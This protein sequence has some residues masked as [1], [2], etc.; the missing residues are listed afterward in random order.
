MVDQQ[1]I[2]PN[3]DHRASEVFDDLFAGVFVD[4]T[5]W[6]N[7]GADKDSIERAREIASIRKKLNALMKA[8]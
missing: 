3:S 7:S 8:T 2:D 5:P 6:Q 4:H 1:I